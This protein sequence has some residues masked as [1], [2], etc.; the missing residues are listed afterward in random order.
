MKHIDVLYIT[1][2]AYSGSTILGFIL[3]SSP[4][5]FNA[6]ELQY[7]N[8]IQKEDEM[9]TCGVFSQQCPFWSNIYNNNYTIYRN[10]SF[11]ERLKISSYILIKK[12]VNPD[13]IENSPEYKLLH[14]IFKDAI[15][16]KPETKYI[17]DNSKSLWR[18]IHLLKCRGINLKVIFIKRDIL[19]NIGSFVK[20]RKGFWR[21]L[22]RYTIMNYFI[23]RLLINNNINYII[24]NYNNL[25]NHP[26]QEIGKIEKLFK[27]KIKEYINKL[28]LKNTHVATG[29][30][31]TRKSL[32]N[33][34][35]LYPD[36]SWKEQLLIFQKRV[37]KIIKPII[38]Q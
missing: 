25:C 28:N 31:G 20:H 4:Q 34:K 35:G 29:N 24:I 27:I 19:G 5:I 15:N 1:S 36:D 11:W 16:Y 2:T 30:M 3:G 9:C 8:K 21:G 38:N 32:D 33:Y 17:I 14:N 26:D 10:P 37:L 7:F 22:F 13:I 12:K 18:L 6:G 23:K